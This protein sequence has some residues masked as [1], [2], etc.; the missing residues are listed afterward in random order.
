[1][2]EK[3]PRAVQNNIDKILAIENIKRKLNALDV[4][5]IIDAL[6]SAQQK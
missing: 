2:K 1:L 3:Y 6:Y 4:F 5:I